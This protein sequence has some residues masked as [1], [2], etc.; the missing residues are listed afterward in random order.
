MYNIILPAIP[1]LVSFAYPPFKISELNTEISPSIRGKNFV[2]VGKNY[3]VF[4][5]SKQ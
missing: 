4:K 2:V 5:H 3:L 1:S